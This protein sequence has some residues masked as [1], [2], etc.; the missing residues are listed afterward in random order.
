MGFEEKLNDFLNGKRFLLLAWLAMF[1][2]AIVAAKS[3]EVVQQADG[4]GLFFDISSSYVGAPM[5]SMF[6][7][8]ALVTAIGV[9]MLMLNKVFSFVRSVTDTLASTFFLL[10]MANPLT[11]CA[12]NAGTALTLVLALGAFYA[13]SSYNDKHAQHSIFL[14]F[15]IITMCVMFQWAFVV[16]IPAFFIG[17]CYMRTMNWRSL[18]ATLLGIFVPFWIVVGMGIASPADFKLPSTTASWAPLDK[19]QLNAMIVAV[20]VT[21]VA[22][23]TI[24]T[25]NLYTIINY[26]LQLRVYNMFFMVASVLT[27][28][29]M[30]LNYHEIHIYMPI[31]NLCLAVQLAHAFT[32]SKFTQRYVYILLLAVWALV[33]SAGILYM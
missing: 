5:L 12:F 22:T 7:N 15:F 28:V 30:L 1:I 14:T 13:F 26:R 25:L 21:A 24:T 2:S 33:S 3:G 8:V 29:A 9:L 23:L 18:V 17:F 4:N 16:L 6:I 10:T 32:T 20:C 19:G 11:N 31:L 27:I